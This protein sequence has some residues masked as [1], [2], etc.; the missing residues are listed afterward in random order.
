[1]SEQLATAQP[2]PSA[3]EATAVSADIGSTAQPSDPVAKA[4]DDFDKLLSDIYD[5]NQ[6]PSAPAQKPAPE[7]KQVSDQPESA[8]AEPAQSSPAIAPPHSWSA[9]AKAKWNA[10]PPDVQ[11]YIA[12]RESEAHKAIT[13]AGSELKTYQPLR[14]ALEQFRG[15]YPAGQEAQF[16]QSLMQANAALHHDPVGTLK[17]LAEYYNVDPAQLTGQKPPQQPDSNSVE[18]LFRDPRL[19]KEVLPLVQTMAQRVR[20]L[21]GQLTA[22]ERAE[23]AERQEDARKIIAEFSKDRPD[24]AE[25]QDEIAREAKIIREAEPRL[26]MDKLLERAYDRARWANPDVRKRI[27]DAE[28]A[29]EAERVRQETIKKQNEAKKLAAMNVRTGASAPTPATNAKWNDEQALGALYDQ[30]TSR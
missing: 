2:E 30:I 26:P 14:S 1:M 23:A 27:L 19:D 6:E 24:I 21:E 3:P 13:Q 15:Y 20:Q 17:A 29:A 28:K 7:P 11:T 18:D 5:R 25:L 22:R 4:A 10:L 8:A 12:Q 16:V 9:E